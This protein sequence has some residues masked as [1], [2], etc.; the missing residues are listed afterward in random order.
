[1][2]L[3]SP[4]AA[5]AVGVIALSLVGC[6][7]TQGWATAQKPVNCA[8][9][10]QEF[11]YSRRA[12]GASPPEVYVTPPGDVMQRMRDAKCPAPTGYASLPRSRSASREMDNLMKPAAFPINPPQS[13]NMDVPPTSGR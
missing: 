7:E 9:L 11:E 10:N 2:R 1:M 4:K 8:A 5:L 13:L 12:Y 6:A 3:N